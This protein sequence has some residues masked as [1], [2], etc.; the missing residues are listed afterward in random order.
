MLSLHGQSVG[1]L[2]QPRDIIRKEDA[3][4]RGVQHGIS[5]HT[6]QVS[7]CPL[8]VGSALEDVSMTAATDEKIAHKLGFQPTGWIV[9]DYETSASSPLPTRIKR[10]SWDDKF[11]TLQSNV[12]CTVD[13]WVF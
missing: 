10:I 6:E 7:Q 8:I 3:E 4:T 11:I 13:L 12:D 5:A 2:M 9:V 1:L